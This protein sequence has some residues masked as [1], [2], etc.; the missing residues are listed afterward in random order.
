LHTSGACADEDRWLDEIEWHEIRPG[1]RRFLD[2]PPDADYIPL[3]RAAY[4][5]FV[6]HAMAGVAYHF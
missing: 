2:A 6:G 1:T 4:D 5:R 3:V